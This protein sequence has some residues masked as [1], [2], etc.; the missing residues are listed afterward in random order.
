MN[1]SNSQKNG[2]SRFKI[3][4]YESFAACSHNHIKYRTTLMVFIAMSKGTL[5]LFLWGRN[6]IVV[7]VRI[8]IN[9]SP[10]H[11]VYNCGII[12]QQQSQKTWRRK[13]IPNSM[14]LALWRALTRDVVKHF[15][16]V[17][18]LA[19]NQSDFNLRCLNFGL[20]VH[21]IDLCFENSFGFDE[22]SEL[23]EKLENHTLGILITCSLT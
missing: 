20:L 11:V 6:G 12:R 16:L 2:H 13:H 19:L 21:K 5:T 4:L 3:L 10:I 15:T 7:G 18:G 8:Q 9:I 23:D 22:K 1:Y 14:A 17:D